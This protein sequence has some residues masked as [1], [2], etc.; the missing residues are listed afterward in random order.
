MPANPTG[1]YAQPDITL[2]GT[3]QNPVTVNISATN[4]RTGTT[5][6]VTSIPEYGN[7]TNAAGALSGTDASSTA[8]VSITLST[9]YQSILTATATFTIQTAMY[10]DGEKIEKVRVAATA[11][12]GSEAFYITESGKEIK[13]GELMAKLMK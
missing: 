7:S 8:S 10:W 9:S 11:G 5:V 3:T 13:A 2:P 1:S 6:T 12:K 4:I